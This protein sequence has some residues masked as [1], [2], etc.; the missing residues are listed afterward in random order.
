SSARS[1]ATVSPVMAP[2]SVLVLGQGRLLRGRGLLLVARLP[3]VVR[4]AVDALAGL[5]VGDLYAAL[6][7]RLA[8]PA[9]EAVPAEAGEVHQV[10]VLDI[11]P[12]AQVLDQRAEGRGLELGAGLLVALG[13]HR[14][15]LRKDG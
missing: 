15:L 14:A 4:H 5:R 2:P 13:R 9:A 12:L 8:V 10:D 6:L 11:G 3:F 1:A 7:G